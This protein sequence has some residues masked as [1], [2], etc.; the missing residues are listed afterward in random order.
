MNPT[1][2]QELRPGVLPTAATPSGLPA[3]MYRLPLFLAENDEV[4]RVGGALSRAEAVIG[5][6]IPSA[7]LGH[8]PPHPT[9]STF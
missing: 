8:R 1:A 5:R 9:A 2:W 7:P 3:A 6:G 4:A